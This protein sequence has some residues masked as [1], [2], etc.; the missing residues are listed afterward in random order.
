MIFPR[1]LIFGNNLLIIV[2]SF[3]LKHGCDN[4]AWIDVIFAHEKHF[5][6][7]VQYQMKATL[8]LTSFLP[9]LLL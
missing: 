4:H 8:S 3:G 2:S 1:S 6:S 7:P 9:S 5:D